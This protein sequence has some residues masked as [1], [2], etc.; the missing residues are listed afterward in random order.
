M[1]EPTRFG[2]LFSE[3]LVI[4]LGVLVALGVDEWRGVLA[5]RSLER[6]YLERL[7][8]ELRG[9]RLVLDGM[10]LKHDGASRNAD[11]VMPYLTGQV[12][13]P[14]DTATVLAA[15]YRSGRSL[16]ATF[17]G[18]FPRTTIRELQS[19]GR[20]D[21]IQDPELRGAILQYYA[22]IDAAGAVLDLLPP[23]Y[24]N[25]VRRRIPAS[26]QAT[27]RSTCPVEGTAADGAFECDIPFGG[28]DAKA[29]LRQVSG[30]S[31]LAGDLNL[32][33]QQLGISV[34]WVTAL[35]EQT[36]LLLERIEDRQ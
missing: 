18:E 25:F 26:I 2:R 7:E 30:N 33:R 8:Q 6:Q 21:L 27:I 16:A 15:L 23:D 1:S 34:G 28:F 12:G 3:F 31:A 19:T 24:R 5:D 35:L 11:L 32:S 17:S 20:L 36:D 10:R 14:S 22:Q 9:G 29:L 4:V 13:L